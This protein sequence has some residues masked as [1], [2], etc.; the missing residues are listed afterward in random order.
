MRTVLCLIA[1]GV[2]A[3][4]GTAYS[5]ELGKEPTKVL[6]TKAMYLVSGLH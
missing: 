2:V 3:W 6:G 1:V 4:T 5:Q